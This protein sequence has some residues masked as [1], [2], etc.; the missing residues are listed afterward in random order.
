MGTPRHAIP[1]SF[2]IKIPSPLKSGVDYGFRLIKI[3]I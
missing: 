3:K 2:S 1:F